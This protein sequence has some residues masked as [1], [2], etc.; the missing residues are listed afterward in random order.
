M[1][2]NRGRG[3]QALLICMA[4]LSLSGCGGGSSGATVTSRSSP[5]CTACSVG[6]TVSGLGANESVVLLNNGGNQLR[7]TSNGT[8]TF[9]T[10]EAASGAYDVTV[11][12][13]TP[14]IACSVSN[15]SGVIDTSNEA[16]VAVLCTTGTETVIHSFAGD[17]TDGQYPAGLVIDGAG[18]LYGVTAGGGAY[19]SGTVFKVSATGQVSILYSFRGGTTDGTNPLAGLVMDSAGNLYGVTSPGGANG[20][21][22]VFKISPSGTEAI[23]Y[24]FANG[25]YPNGG[26]V[27]DSA[28]NL[29]GTTERGGANDD[30]AVFKINPNGTG[31]ILYSFANVATNG[32]FP[33]PGLIMDS[34]GNLYGT[35]TGGGANSGDGTVFK[36]SPTGTETV[37][38]FFAGGTADGT[39]PM[40]GLVTDSA[41]N[42]YGTTFGGGAYGLGTVFKISP[43]GA[44]TVLHSFAGG[45]IDGSNFG[46]LAGGPLLVDG[47]GNIY[48][49]TGGGGAYG[50]G[51]VFKISP[52]GAETVL[53]S[54]GGSSNDGQAPQSLISDSAGNLYGTTAGGGAYG[55]GTVF[56]IN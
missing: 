4:A 26:L 22:T 37:L 50:S 27:M 9:S 10:R 3:V 5:P 52:T 42:L 1:N 7:V 49:T 46:H 29:Y 51:T 36:V 12:S 16:N 11:Q 38:H 13:H 44:E 47:V 23:L 33:A 25:V 54:F 21:G 39:N 15:G 31:A 40:S 20:N 34:V 14:G 43:A 55:L 41:G 48:G 28:G 30:G 8:F 17:S 24:S 45:T 56:E 18:D 32:A 53:Y 35:T 6:G 2:K 19:G